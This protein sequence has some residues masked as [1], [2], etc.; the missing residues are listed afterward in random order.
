MESLTLVTEL[1]LGFSLLISLLAGN[2]VAETRSTKTASA[3][4]VFYLTDCAYRFP[5]KVPPQESGIK[6]LSHVFRCAWISLNLDS[7]LSNLS[8][9]S[10]IALRISRNVADIFALSVWPKVKILLFRK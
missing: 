2:S 9:N 7:A 5:A 4:N 10:H 1:S 3:T 6:P 8:L